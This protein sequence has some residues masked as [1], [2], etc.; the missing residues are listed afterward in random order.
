M[1][2]IENSRIRKSCLYEREILTLYL[3]Y[4]GYINVCVGLSSSVLSFA[5]LSSKDYTL[6]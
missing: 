3:V 6:F 5:L 1:S 2:Y 4:L